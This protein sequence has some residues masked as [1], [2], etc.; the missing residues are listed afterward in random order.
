MKRTFI[1]G[2]FAMV[3][4]GIGLFVCEQMGV[5]PQ[6]TIFGVGTGV[7]AAIVRIGTPIE[8]LAG[9]LIGLVLG[10]ILVAMQIGILPGGSNNIGVA[11]SLVVVFVIV[12]LIHGLTGRRI[13]AWS[14]LLG[15]LAMGAGVYPA[16]A[17]DPFAAPGLF[18]TAALTQIAMGM[19]G[20]LAVIPA[21]RFPDE[22][23]LSAAP[24]AE[25]KSD[26]SADST[27]VADDSSQNA[28]AAKDSNS[29]SLLDDI[30][31]GK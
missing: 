22:K 6:N 3:I 26:D 19:I 24:N 10:T 17:A 25:P 12:G 9:Y 30:V 23:A 4:G 15:V 1:I 2:L 27:D 21:Q 28:D 18:P 29:A 31:G 14:M 16:L 7:I 20:F 5:N 8:R 13:Q 11:I